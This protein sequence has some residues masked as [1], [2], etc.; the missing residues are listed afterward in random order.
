MGEL[1]EPETGLAAPPRLVLEERVL[2][3]LLAHPRAWAEISFTLPPD[4]FTADSRYEIYAAMITLARDG[5][6]WHADEVEAEL[7][8][9]TSKRDGEAQRALGGDGGPWALMYLRRLRQ[10]QT[11]PETPYQASRK[12][13]LEDSCARMRP[14]QLDAIRTRMRQVSNRRPPE[15]AAW[16]DQRRSADL[17]PDQ[18]PYSLQQRPRG[19]AP[20]P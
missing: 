7:A 9:R 5:Q 13:S 16:H 17:L 1:T 14:G 10:G 18:G 19:P 15:A 11:D 2:T 3:G 6:R 8:R 20:S 4:S 12:I